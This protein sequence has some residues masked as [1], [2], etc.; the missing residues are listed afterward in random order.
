MN[1]LERLF[2]IPLDHLSKS[3]NIPPWFCCNFFS[4][5]K[6]DEYFQLKINYPYTWLFCLFGEGGFLFCFGGGVVWFVSLNW[7]ELQGSASASQGM[8]L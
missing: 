3:N 1:I 6:K 4:L 8:G 5:N 2:K 7:P